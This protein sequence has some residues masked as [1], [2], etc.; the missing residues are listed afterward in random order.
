MCCALQEAEAGDMLS[1]LQRV[2]PGLL[3]LVLVLQQNSATGAWGIAP[4]LDQARGLL[5][6]A[7]AY[8]QEA[9][10]AMDAFEALVLPELASLAPE[11]KLWE[12][13]QVSPPGQLSGCKTAV[14]WSRL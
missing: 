1:S 9:Q 8:L 13:C 10:R 6:A 12:L 7:E 5:L 4:A 2:V 3:N 11:L 14:K